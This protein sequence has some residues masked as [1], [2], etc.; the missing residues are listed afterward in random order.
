MRLK[1][2]MLLCSLLLASLA[3]A[4][5]FASDSFKTRSGKELTITFIK[6]GSLMLTYD[7]R[8]IQ[9]DPVSEYA[10]YTAFPKADLILITHEHGDHLDPK[11]IQAVEK[12]GT[13]IIANENSQKKLGKG[14]VLRNGDTDTSVG[15]VTIEAVP[16]Y[17]STPGRDKYHPRH[18]DNG[19]VLTFDG[20]RVYIAGDTE[21]IPEMKELK[22]IDIAFL[23]V[24]QPYTMTVAQAAQAARMFSPKILYPYHYGN[25]KVEELKEALK[26]SGI[27]VRIRELR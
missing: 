6:H 17:N 20:L 12:E 15:A 11:A 19:Y 21:T 5:N 2:C 18:R 9:V 7:N 16:A 8:S 22:E 23:P 14:K 25:T 27:D 13:E 26:G 4:G 1:S 10:D 24:N 3:S